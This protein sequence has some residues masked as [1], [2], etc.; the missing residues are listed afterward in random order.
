MW[1]VDSG[2]GCVW[3]VGALIFKEGLE[4][5]VL[6]LAGLQCSEDPLTPQAHPCC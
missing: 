3:D 6:F 1:D 5:N 2:C 4:V